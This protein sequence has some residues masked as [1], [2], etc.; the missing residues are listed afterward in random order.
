[1]TLRERW[2]RQPQTLW[3]RRAL[4]QVHLWTGIGV[5]LYVVVVSVSGSAIVF[6]SELYQRFSRGPVIVI[7]SGARLTEEELEDA[8]R[9][10]YP[11]FAVSQF[12]KTQNTDAAVEI[13][14]DR[15]GTSRRRLFNPYTGQDLGESVPFG[16]RAVSWLID[17]HDNLLYGRPGRLVNGLG[18]IFLTVLCL[19]GAV[20]WWPGAR[21]WR[22]SVLIKWRANWQRVN[23]DLH[24]AIGFWTFAILFI[25]AV[26]GIY[27]SF[28]QPFAAVVDFFEPPDEL[29]L[30]PRS[31][32]AILRWL[33]NLH[34]G[35]FAGWPV[36]V[37]W[38]ALGLVPPILFVSGAI[39]WWNRV[40]RHRG[41]GAPGV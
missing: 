5:G 8:A 38:T 11:G 25:W 29:S 35:R 22:R 9:R 16:I 2:A 10:A 14:L 4:F 19:T 12:W 31:G 27:F 20:I 26:T 18:A 41:S 23:W 13:W 39:M 6:R 21:T 1:M 33:I 15:G 7:R 36:K 34:F 17:L 24:S 3:L 28:P 30:E 32:D 37:L 40:L